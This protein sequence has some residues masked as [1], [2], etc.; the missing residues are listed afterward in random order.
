MEGEE[1]VMAAQGRHG[2][3]EAAVEHDEEGHAVEAVAEEGHGLG[4]VEEGHGLEASE[5]HGVEAAEEHAMEASAR[6]AWVVERV[7]YMEDWDTRTELSLDED[8]D[9]QEEHSMALPFFILASSRD[10]ACHAREIQ[11]QDD[12][13]THRQRWRQR[14]QLHTM[15][16]S[17]SVR[18][19][20]KQHPT[21]QQSPVDHLCI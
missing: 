18:H 3:E 6:L 11:P 19:P 1:A 10:V 9:L 12:Q 13:G 20:N 14:T 2:L 8:F 21:Q 5:G 15:P 7:P 17:H 4:T 16:C